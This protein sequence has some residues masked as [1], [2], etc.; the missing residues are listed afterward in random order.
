M[1]KLLVSLFIIGNLLG[2]S[3]YV[4]AEPLAVDIGGLKF[5]VPLQ[6]VD[7]IQLYS[8]RDRKGYPAAQSVLI[9]KGKFQFAAGAAA[10]L[11][12]SENVPFVSL[13]TRLSESF[14][15]TSDNALWFGLW[16]GQESHQKD[17]TYGISASIS[18]W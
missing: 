9:E 7:A 1:K 18:L 10:V 8:F 15:D 12:T 16:I 11:G 5:I 17:S 14:F 6:K 3:G 4:S 13:Q 2:I